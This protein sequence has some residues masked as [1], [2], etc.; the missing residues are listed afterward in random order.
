MAG[1]HLAG[2]RLLLAIVPFAKWREFV[3]FEEHLLL[4][5]QSL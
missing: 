2:L 5:K 1:E 4:R 3:A